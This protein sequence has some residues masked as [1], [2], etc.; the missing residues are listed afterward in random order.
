MLIIIITYVNY[1]SNTGKILIRKILL[2]KYFIQ[3]LVLGEY[4]DI[5]T[6]F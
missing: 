6:K 4:V 2:Y 1:Y 5:Y 3:M